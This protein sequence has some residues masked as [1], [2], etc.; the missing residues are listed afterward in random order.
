MD[1]NELEQIIDMYGNDI[2]SFCHYLTRNRED[3]EDLFQDVF[4][5]A[6]RKSDAVQFGTQTKS[7]LLSIAVRRWKNRKRKFAWRKRITDDRIIPVIEEN[8]NAEQNNSDPVNI[9][10]TAEIQKIVRNSVDSLQEKLK[11]PLLLYYMEGMKEREIAEILSI[12]LG[13]V[14]SRISQAKVKLSKLITDKLP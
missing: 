3:A 1:K 12:P 5:V 13:T 6:F 7:F 11:L 4:L 8:R 2:L 14:K 9:A 10:S